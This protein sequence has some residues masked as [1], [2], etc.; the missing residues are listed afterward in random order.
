[1]DWVQSKNRARIFKNASDAHLLSYR[2][3]T[4]CVCGVNRYKFENLEENEE[5]YW[6]RLLFK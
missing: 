5:S 2:A 3:E 6:M 4:S 1:M